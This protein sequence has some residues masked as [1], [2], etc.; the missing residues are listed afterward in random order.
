MYAQL[1]SSGHG[2]L[3]TLDQRAGIEYGSKV[4]KA[5]EEIYKARGV[6]ETERDA[7]YL[8]LAA[9][10]PDEQGKGSTAIST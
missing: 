5:F 9:T 6:K 1:S 2:K 7:W 8:Q 3:V 4:E 10:E